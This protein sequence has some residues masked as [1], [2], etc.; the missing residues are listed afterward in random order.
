[1]AGPVA[2]LKIKLDG[3]AEYKAALSSISASFKELG[4]EMSLLSAKYAKN[5]DSTEALA[6]K[7]DILSRKVEAQKDRVSTL[8]KAVEEAR[9]IQEKANRTFSETASSL[10]ESSEEYKNMAEQVRKAE[11][12]TSEWQTKLNYAE[13]ELYKLNDSLDEN[14]EALR[15]AESDGNG[16]SSALDKIKGALGKAKEEGTGAKGVFEN[17]K[18]AFSGGEKSS[19]GLGDAISQ[20]AGKLGINL[21]EGADKALSSLN[22]ISAGSAAAVGGLAA[23]AAAIVS[24]EKKL[25]SMTKESAAYAKEL[26]T[27]ASVTG[28]STQEIQELQYASEMIGVSY[29]RIKDSLKEVTNKMQEAQNGSEDTAAAFEQLGVNIENSD[30]SLRDAN[31]VFYETIDALGK[32]E[33]KTERDALAMDL[34]SESAQELNPLIEKGSQSLKDY[35][36]EAHE[37]GYV[38]DNDAVEAL[39]RADEAQQKLLKTQEAVTN[40]ISAEYAPYMTEALTD[41]ADFISKIGKALKDSGVVEKFGS[42]LDSTTDILAPLGELIEIT[43]PALEKALSPIATLMALIADTTNLLVGLL[44]LNGDKIKTA[45]GMNISSG[46]LSN[47]QQLKYGNSLNSSTYVSGVGYTGTGGYI[48]NDGKWHQN[49][50]GSE[51]WLGGVTWVGENGPEPV[52]LPQ[53]AK[54]G[55]NQDGRRLSGGDTYNITIPASDIREFNDIVRIVQNQRRMNRMGVT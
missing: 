28:Q 1:M 9:A 53:G 31:D 24:V 52:W 46:Q 22:G 15:K 40:Q 48:G 4:S 49:A 18:E 3:E 33:N 29:D 26:K 50:S 36:D 54:I 17:L 34:L 32:I 35:A 41:T 30:G 44:T 2:N 39:A 7:N 16:F 11:K 37:M 43:L 42:I 55:T 38:L 45:L 5:A 25:I 19:V 51:N 27:L 20:V 23:L 14:S 12:Q 21:P 10:D 6:E 13:A 8:Q 47:M